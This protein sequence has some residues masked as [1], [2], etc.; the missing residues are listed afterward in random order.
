VLVVVRKIEEEQQ[1]QDHCELLKQTNS[2]SAKW[3]VAYGNGYF[4]WLFAGNRI[5]KKCVA[6][7]KMGS[8]ESGSMNRKRSKWQIDKR[9]AY[10]VCRMRFFRL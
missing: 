5:L 6:R 4:S 10:P 1:Q 3:H 9:D 7:A 8:E 2:V